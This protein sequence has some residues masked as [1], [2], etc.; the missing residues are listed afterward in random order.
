MRTLNDFLD[1]YVIDNLK[2]SEKEY[3][4]KVFLK[5]N[6]YPNL[7]Q[8]WDLLDEQWRAHNCSQDVQDEKI[9]EFYRHPVWI[10]NGLFVDQDP[11]SISNRKL[12]AKAVIKKSPKRVL[13]F[14]GGFGGLARIISRIDSEIKIDIFD[15]FPFSIG[16]SILKNY[17]NIDYVHEIK[18]KY[19]VI[20]ATD[21]LEHLFDPIGVVHS[22]SQ[23]LNF[24]GTYLIANCFFPVILCHIPSTFHLEYSFDIIMQKLGFDTGRTVLYGK[25]YVR[26]NNGDLGQARDIE[27]RSQRIYKF[28]RFLPY[29][30][31]KIGVFL[32]NLSIKYGKEI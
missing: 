10:L 6:G 21:V 24:G 12:F 27:K 15:E 23:Y 25:E 18:E 13:D 30:R 32:I 9:M 28:I 11:E 8:I 26:I 2:K 3:L 14:G 16:E 17:Q 31:K 22:S 20:I 29:F 4:E 19:D 7:E 1:S 5:F